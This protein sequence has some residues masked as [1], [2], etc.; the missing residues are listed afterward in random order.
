MCRQL[1]LARR[2]VLPAEAAATLSLPAVIVPQA[3]VPL[4]QRRF[5]QAALEGGGPQKGGV[6]THRHTHQHGED[7]LDEFLHR[8]TCPPAAT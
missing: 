8:H 5:T 4:I 7:L 1:C 3:D 2:A 6:L